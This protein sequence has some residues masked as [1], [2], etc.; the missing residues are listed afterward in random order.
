M[1]QRTSTDAETKAILAAALRGELTE[2]E[3]EWLDQQAVVARRG[4]WRAR[5]GRLPA[6]IWQPG[7]D[8]RLHG[9]LMTLS[10]WPSQGRW[11]S[12]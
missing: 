5:F 12:P 7:P 6:K 10:A 3:A 9:P 8:A 1:R 11:L 4:C 2:D